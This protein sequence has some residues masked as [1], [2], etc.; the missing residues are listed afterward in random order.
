MVHGLLYLPDAHHE[1][2]PFP[3]SS[4]PRPPTRPRLVLHL[5]RPSPLS[6][7]PWA[8]LRASPWRLCTK[9]PKAN[10][11]GLGQLIRG[12][13]QVKILIFIIGLPSFPVAGALNHKEKWLW[14]FRYRRAHYDTATYVSL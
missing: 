5:S 4:L 1:R 14:S 12:I 7:V 10:M 2:I 13:S 6:P 11:H 9:F 8:R 3:V